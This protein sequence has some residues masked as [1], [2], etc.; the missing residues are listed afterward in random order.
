MNYLLDED[1]V[2]AHAERE[3][4]LSTGSILGIFF[5]LVLLCGLFFGFGYSVGSHRPAPLAQA[6]PNAPAAANFNAF[7]PAAGLTAGAAGTVPPPPHPA[8]AIAPSASSASAPVSS[9]K[10]VTGSLS[11]APTPAPIV[12]VPP[13][14]PAHP[15][16]VAS[17][18][19][20]SAPVPTANGTFLVQVAAVSHQQDSALLM[21]ALRIKGYAPSAFLEADKLIH[22]QLG[23]YSTRHDAEIMRQRLVADGYSPIIK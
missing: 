3:F 5:G 10:A 8:A 13:A 4:T 9:T 14:T 17:A 21:N 7:K 23:P 6:S 12:R 16:P 15:A 18:P 19:V 20:A 22:V 11:P 2:P 1:D